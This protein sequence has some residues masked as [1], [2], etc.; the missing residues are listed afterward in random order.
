MQRINITSLLKR[1][2]KHE[3]EPIN[4]YGNEALEAIDDFTF[5]EGVNYDLVL[6]PDS[7]RIILLTG[8]IEYTWQSYCDICLEPTESVETVEITEDIYPPNFDPY[9]GVKIDGNYQHDG[10]PDE[11]EFLFHNGRTVD[12]SKYIIDEV[13]LNLPIVVRCSE[14]CPG[15]CDLCGKKNTENHDCIDDYN[16]TKELISVRP[17]FDKLKELL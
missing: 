9:E 17:E 2:G 6:W 14:D 1:Y 7:Q 8:V 10:D 15:L 12:L 5:P 11:A 13:S 3:A 16:D 4:I